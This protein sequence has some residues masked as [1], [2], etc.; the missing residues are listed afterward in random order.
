MDSNS[1]I[2]KETINPFGLPAIKYLP[3]DGSRKFCFDMASLEDAIQFYNDALQ[4]VHAH[5]FFEIIYIIEGEG[6]TSSTMMIM[7]F[8][9]IPYSFYLRLSSINLRRSEVLKAMS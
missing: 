5:S 9:D 3:A 2:K 1:Y 4:S 7:R 8:R 6:N